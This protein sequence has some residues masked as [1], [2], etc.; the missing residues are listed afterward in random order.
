MFQ[1]TALPLLFLLTVATQ[2]GLNVPAFSAPTKTAAKTTPEETAILREGIAL[3][4]QRKYDEAY[5]KF[6]RVRQAS[7]DNRPRFRWPW[8]TTRRRSSRRP[9][10]RCAMHDA[11]A[12]AASLGQCYGL[13]QHAGCGATPAAERSLKGIEFAGRVALL[14][15]SHGAEP[16]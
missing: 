11:I 16:V 5:L 4:E 8:S 13:T 15:P 1:R 7:P 6:D 10:I 9:S 14:A 3:F 2:Q 12:D